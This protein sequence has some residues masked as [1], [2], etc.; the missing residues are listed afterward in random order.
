M[1]C[2]VAVEPLILTQLSRV[3]IDG[4]RCWVATADV[5]HSHDTELVHRV[6]AEAVHRVLGACDVRDLVVGGAGGILALVLNDVRLD[7]FGSY[8]RG[9]GLP[10]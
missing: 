5:I 8:Q 6:R 9:V 10:R 2:V 7:L 4:G 3:H 1:R